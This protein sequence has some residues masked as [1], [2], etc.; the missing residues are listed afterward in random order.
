MKKPI[1]DVGQFTN[2]NGDEVYY[3]SILLPLSSDQENV[4]Y[5]LVAFSFKIAT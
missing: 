4:D 2:A 3:R 1:A 5:V